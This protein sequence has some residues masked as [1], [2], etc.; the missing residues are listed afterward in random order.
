MTGIRVTTCFLVLAA[1]AFAPALAAKGGNAPKVKKGQY[2]TQFF[3]TECQFESEGANSFFILQP[4]YRLVLE[5]ESTQVIITVLDETEVVDGVVTRVV[6]E[7]ESE[8]GEI[9]EVSRNFFALCA[10]TSDVYYF[11]EDVD[12]YEDGEVVSHEG[13]WRSG[14]DG[15]Q[16]GVLMPGGALLGSRYYQE[17]APGVALDRAEHVAL[18]DAFTVEAGEF[19]NILFV[20]ETSGL[21]KNS[22]SLKYYAA[23]IGLIKDDDVELVEYGF[24]E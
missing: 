4:G 22:K 9:V 1:L 13:E 21:E 17:I 3:P 7:R 19:E 15:A 24:V 16:A 20:K 14:I 2:S 12:I 6:E 8:D 5:G 23:G 18:L 10:Q 11:G